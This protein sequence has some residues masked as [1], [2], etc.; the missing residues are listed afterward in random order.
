MKRF[1]WLSDLARPPTSK[2]ASFA[3]EA[4][5]LLGSVDRDGRVRF[6]NPGWE[7][8][9][10]YDP[11]ETRGRLL[12]ELIPLEHAAA[13]RLVSRL[14]DPSSSDP[15]EISLRAKDGTPRHYL[16]HRRYDAQEDRTYIAG[17]EL[18]GK[19]DPKD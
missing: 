18:V 2:A 6:L 1:L 17:E 16:W 13:L 12:V 5:F 8:A 4:S 7:R 10:G 11:K 15:L 3:S 19:D 14:V 9:L